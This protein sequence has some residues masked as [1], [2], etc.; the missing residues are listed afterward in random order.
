[1]LKQIEA[2]KVQQSS[3]K[4]KYEVYVAK[5]DEFWKK[6]QGSPDDMGYAKSLENNARIN[7]QSAQDQYKEADG[8]S[9]KLLSYS[10]MTT[11]SDLSNKAIE[12]IKKAFDIYA[13]TSFTQASIPQ[14]GGTTK[15]F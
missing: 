12:D 6:F 14:P 10:S 7:F 8:K 9:D 3:N 15:T 5:A 1:M 2:L 13:N 11:A 4:M